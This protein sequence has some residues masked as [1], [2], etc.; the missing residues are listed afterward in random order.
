MDGAKVLG[1]IVAFL[2]ILA[3]LILVTVFIVKFSWG[4]VVPDL[5]P[6]AVAQGLVVAELSWAM[7][8]KLAIVLSLLGEAFAKAS[9]SNRSK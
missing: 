9:T 5:F 7:T 4:L 3:V 1:L 8:F 2:M 6:G